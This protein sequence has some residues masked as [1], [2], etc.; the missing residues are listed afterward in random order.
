MVVL[1][2]LCIWLA[3]LD[4]RKHRVSEE[5]EAREREERLLATASITPVAAAHTTEHG[6]AGDDG[7]SGGDLQQ[8]FHEYPELP[9]GQSLEEP[10]PDAGESK[11]TDNP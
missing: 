9:G 8:E 4:R 6:A 3:W 10:S 5:Q 2:E 11:S 1:F 7:W